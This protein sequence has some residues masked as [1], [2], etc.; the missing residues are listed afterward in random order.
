MDF[1]KIIEWVKLTPKYLFPIALASG[2]LLFGPENLL[3]T[4]G[5]CDFAEVHKS[6]IG[7]VLLLSTALL[8]GA[9]LANIGNTLMGFISVKFK[10][11]IYR[12]RLKDLTSEE[13]EVLKMYL[14]K[15][16]RTCLFKIS[17]GPVQNLMADK[18][19]F[20]TGPGI[21]ST[22][23]NVGIQTWAWRYLMKNKRL[24]K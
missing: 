6:Y 5:V 8:L 20:K 13:K 11:Y 7:F 4:L 10:S 21:N 23:H 2:F 15:D 16:N 18:I 17:H 24:L 19:L 9:F 12:T 22:T 14:D 3:S 1:P